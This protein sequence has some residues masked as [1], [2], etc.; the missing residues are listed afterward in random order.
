MKPIVMLVLPIVLA[1]A[2]T[3][4]STG[5]SR[6]PEP[7]PGQSSVHVNRHVDAHVP[8]REGETTTK[9]VEEPIRRRPAKDP[10]RSVTQPPA[11]STPTPAQPLR[12]RRY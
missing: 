11:P 3:T 1:A 5:G 8:A 9:G 12:D 10:F 2:G 7:A 4:P 6:V